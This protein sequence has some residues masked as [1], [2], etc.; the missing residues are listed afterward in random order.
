[1]LRIDGIEK[2]FGGATALAGVSAY[3]T[4]GEVRALVGENGAGKS[5]L[6]KVISG[7][8]APDRGSLELD[9]ELVRWRSPPDALAR[10]FARV[11]QEPALVPELS[12][13]EN[14]ALG[15]WPRRGPFVDRRELALRAVRALDALGLGLDPER[16]AGEL[17]LSEAQLVEVAAALR[18]GAR[19]IVFDEATSALTEVEAQRLFAEVGRLA[20]SG[21]L[22]LWISHR[23]HEARRLADRVSVLREGRLVETLP[24]SE[25]DDERLALAM[26]GAPGERTRTTRDVPKERLLCVRGLCVPPV[27]ALDH[28]R[29]R[30]EIRGVAGLVGAGK[31][32]LL[33]ALA[34]LRRD[35]RG[36]V[37]LEGRSLGLGRVRSM[38]A[39]GVVLVPEDRLR[40]GLVASLSVVEAS[41]LGALDRW[42]APLGFFQRRA[43]RAAAVA[44][45]DRL[46]VRR[47]SDELAVADLSGGNQQKTLF[48]RAALYHPRELLLDEPSR[49]DDVAAKA[50]LHEEIRARAAGGTGVIVASSDLDE[51]FE[52]CD[53]LLVL[54]EGRAVGVW[55][56]GEI[57][58]LG[59]VLAMT[60]GKL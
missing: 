60:A 28:A 32:E 51:L 38:M 12:V 19:C 45:L 44:Q 46:D 22:V 54:R 3:F 37:E 4:A 13:A 30:G 31:S 11:A 26:S 2:R 9:G 33:Q 47:A 42:R 8:L 52:L 7:V 1:V 57:D 20:A 15:A 23:L 35:A 21:V 24:A 40:Q 49:G 25:A 56:R 6:G 39:R 16:L 18:R 10:G 59:V 29:Q 5:T 14:L 50:R 17:S 27:E 41:L 34:G 58:A 48:A 43:A 53:R 55:S 36:S